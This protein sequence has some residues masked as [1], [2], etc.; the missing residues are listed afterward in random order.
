MSEIEF[1]I[2]VLLAIAGGW[3]IGIVGF[4]QAKM[5]RREIAQLRR[6]VADMCP[7][8]PP[9]SQEVRSP[10]TR[11]WGLPEPPPPPRFVEPT[12]PSRDLEAVLTTRWGVWL[13]AAAL[14]LA[15]VFLVRYAVDQG[16]LGPGPRCVLAGLLGVALI[17][18]AEWLRQQE[19]A[20]PGISDQAAPGLAA[21]GV[22]VLFGASYGAG[23]L[24]ALVSPLAGFVLMAGAS[25]IGLGIA[26]RHGQ[27]VA[28]VG[29]VGAFVT[30]ALVQ[31]ENPSLP[32]LF[33]YLLFVT[34]TTLG[35]V[36]YAAWV[37][38]GWATAIA[39]AIW[40]LVAIANGTGSEAWAPALF[41]P[42]AAMLNLV[43]LRQALDHQIGR[44]LAWVPC[45]A[46]GAAGLLLAVL[47]QG[48]NTRIALLLF[49]PLTIWRAAREDRLRLLPF[50]AAVLFLLLLVGWSIEVRAWPDIT[51]PLGQEAPSVV[52]ALLATAAFV[53]GCFA[54]SGLWFERRS[55]HPL[56][57][58]SL[59]AAVPVLTLAICYARVADFRPRSGWAA[60]AVLVTAGLI[61]AAAMSK[62]ERSADRQAAAGAYA[63]GAVAALALG[64]AMLLR[65][66]WLTIA[67]SLFLPALAWVAT[68]ADLPPLRRVGL[69]VA[70]CIVVRL[71]LNWYVLDYGLGQWP[72]V[73]DLLAA[74]AVPAASFALAAA[75]FRR[76]A[77]DLT[78]AVLEAGSVA[79][80]TVLVALEVHRLC[81]PFG[82]GLRTPE[83][84]FAESALQLASIA[85]LTF[86]TM[87]IAERL[88]R[89]VLHVA[90]RVQGA[91]ALSGGL[92]MILLNPAVL[93][94]PVGSLPLLDWLL[95]AYLLPA[96]LAA[97]AVGEQATAQP[98]NLRT[99]LAGYAVLAG[100][101]WL[102]VEVRHLFNSGAIGLPAVPVRDGELW[103][104]SGAWL[105]YGVAI[106]AIGIRAKARQLRLT[107]LG[108]VALAG[109]K[110]FLVDTAGLVGLWRVL[111][112][113]GLG[114]VLIGL[115]AVYRRLVAPLPPRNA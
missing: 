87:R 49:V 32:G 48:G 77:D 57:W 90:W 111:S 80:V 43:F 105:A 44:R 39:G 110:V 10:E 86:V 93:D 8:P 67:I 45:A 11:P 21:G 100:F 75:M 78:V 107:A 76:D 72:V 51:S 13:G 115:G 5:A 79:F 34:G 2:V 41:A 52:Q 109:A 58:A 33:A 50:L 18:G 15:G 17:V 103:A 1:A 114:L 35:V 102:T 53:A 74:Y 46:L 68:K 26:L 73:N 31:T 85:V 7:A 3:A 98:A 82:D 83:L 56:A 20:R 65:E 25:L 42:A 112:F 16:L 113:L 12:V 94:L 9:P 36:R 108:I 14:V 28:V 55:R 101:V 95:P 37:W 89:P 106:M 38:L 91:L 62:R 6:A 96:L 64:C 60:C 30:P 84:D 29:F 19:A 70:V 4:F 40:M 88:E 22:A 104:W 61:A 92:L 23:V 99:V 63:A 54:A 66:Q 69:A 97:V 81:Q 47:D 59:A 24:Y 27:L 71:L